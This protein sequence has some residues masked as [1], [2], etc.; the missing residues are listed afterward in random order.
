M[1]LFNGVKKQKRIGT[2]N[3][4]FHVLSNKEHQ[5]TEAYDELH[6]LLEDFL[7]ITYAAGSC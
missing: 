7:Q 5:M 2:S 6:M 3:N 4:S 1:L